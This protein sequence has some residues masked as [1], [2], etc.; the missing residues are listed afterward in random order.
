M[1]QELAGAEGDAAQSIRHRHLCEPLRHWNR[2]PLLRPLLQLLGADRRVAGAGALGLGL[3]LGHHGRVDGRSQILVEHGLADEVVSQRR[4]L[5]VLRRVVRVHV[6]ADL[7]EG[8]VRSERAWR[9]HRRQR[10]GQFAGGQPFEHRQRRLEVELVLE[11]GAPSFQQHREV[12]QRLGGR[13]QLLGLQPGEPQRHALLEAALGEQEG[14]PGTFPEAGTEESRCLQR[15]PQQRLEV[16]RRH[17]AQQ[18]RRVHRLFRLHGDG[19][20][21]HVHLGLA[22]EPLLPGGPQRQRQRLVDAP[23]PQRVQDHLLLSVRPPVAAGSGLDM[24]DQ[25]VVGVGQ[26]AAGRLPLPFEEAGEFVRGAGVESEPVQHGLQAGS[27]AVGEPVV[28]GLQ[29]LADAL[30]EVEAAGV[31]LGPPERRA[32]PRRGRSH[33]HVAVGDALDPP[34]LGTQVERFA[35]LRFPHEL[36]V[37][38][39]DDGTGVRMPQREVAAIRDGAA[40]GVQ[41]ERRALAS[42]D[43]AGDAVEGDARLEIADARA[44]VAP[45]E[46]LDHQIEVFPRQR[47]IGRGAGENAEQLVHLP[48]FGGH[49]GDDD[50]RQYVQRIGQRFEGFQ[51]P[52]PHRLGQRRGDQ[53]VLCEGREQLASADLADAMAGP[54]DA[55]Q[56]GGDGGRRLHQHHFVQVADVD[57]HLQGARRHDG[58]QLAAFQPLLHLGADLPRQRAVVGVRHRR[59]RIA[60]H[61]EG[62]L[63][64]QAP[65]VGEEQ[66]RTIAADHLPERVRQRRPHGLAVFRGHPG[67]GRE[68]HLEGDALG[69]L[70]LDDA[71]RTRLAGFAPAAD[72]ARHRRQRPHRGGEG[73]ALHLAGDDH[74]PFEGRHQLDPAAVL[75]HRVDFVQDDGLHRGERLPPAHR[76]EQQIQALRRGDEQLRRPAQHP[77]PLALFRVAAAGLHAQVREGQIRGGE[78]RPDRR[79]GAGEI[80][81]DVVVQRLERRDVEHPGGAGL[82]FAG[83]EGVDRPQKRRQRLAAAGGRGGQQ[84]LAG[85]D[86]RPGAAL[87]VCGLAERVLEPAADLRV[88]LIESGH[89]VH[90]VRTGERAYAVRGARCGRS[91]RRANRP[92]TGR[93]R[94]PSSIPL[95]P[96]RAPAPPNDLLPSSGLRGHFP[97]AAFLRRNHAVRK[98]C[99]SWRQFN[100]D[101]GGSGTDR[102]VHTHLAR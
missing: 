78:P 84:V 99:Q 24:L 38:L 39:A 12:R 16:G 37:Q 29:E 74:Q 49:A 55:L 14:P 96:S 95:A 26:V 50:L 94:P 79:D 7:V 66:R 98:T 56:G 69:A 91:C 8:D 22:R 6:A 17:Q 68:A 44:G 86:P 35:D 47:R 102:G 4:G 67:S 48:G 40:R 3:E 59:R 25:Q 58:A 61:G 64:R 10:P 92:T 60:V 42:G 87:H 71:H 13:H 32:G 34:R 81:T 33:Q 19:V 90:G 27:V 21:V 82:G 11:A 53:E 100:Q 77:L 1:H 63:F 31:V 15:L 2:H 9:G 23:A 18:Q 72:E 75:H 43:D 70:G 46:H 36:L 80:G 65:A 28:G 41:G 45:G 30:G 76:G 62:D 101:C 85:G 5:R 54:P 88:E 73:D 93:T 97:P 57:A 89:G 52:L 83:G 20:V 51:I